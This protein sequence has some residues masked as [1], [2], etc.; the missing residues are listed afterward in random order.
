MFPGSYYPGILLMLTGPS[1]CLTTPA[2]AVPAA[3]STPALSIALLGLTRW[4]AD[5]YVHVL[6]M[7]RGSAL[8]SS[9]GVCVCVCIY[10]GIH[11]HVSLLTVTPSSCWLTH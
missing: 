1:F 7:K 9:A 3:T 8:K 4:N 11:R 10:V 5:T 6:A 2:A